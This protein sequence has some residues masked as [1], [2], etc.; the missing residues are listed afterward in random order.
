M[1][2]ANRPAMGTVAWSDLTVPEAKSISDFYADVAGWE[3]GQRYC[4]IRDPAGA[5]LALMELGGA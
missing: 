1:S 4:V 2:E 5:Y 3:A